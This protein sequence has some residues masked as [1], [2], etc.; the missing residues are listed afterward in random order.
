MYVE[1][2]KGTDS[3]RVNQIGEE[4]SQCDGRLGAGVGPRAHHRG[5]GHL[6]CAVSS[7]QGAEC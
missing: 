7:L 5:K 1:V 2:S 4:Q 3:A 6:A